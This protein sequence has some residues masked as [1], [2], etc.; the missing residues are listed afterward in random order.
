VFE[1]GETAYVNYFDRLARQV[2]GCAANATA[3]GDKIIMGPSWDNVSN[4]ALEVK[5]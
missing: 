1:P 2:T 4:G 3:G 5:F